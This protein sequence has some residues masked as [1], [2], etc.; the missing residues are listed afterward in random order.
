[1]SALRRAA[2]RRLAASAY[3]LDLETA[4][5]V[6]ARNEQGEWQI[7]NKSL[8]RWLLEHEGEEITLILASLTDERPVEVRTCRTCGRD[9]TDPECPTCRA[10]RIRLRG[11]P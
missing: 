9:Y 1:M 10:N 7:G 4:N 6:L 2:I 3:E 11:R 8:A 5:G